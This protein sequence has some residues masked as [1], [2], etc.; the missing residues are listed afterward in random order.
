MQSKLTLNTV[1]H[2]KYQCHKLS[3][4]KF[5]A[6]R[7]SK[8]PWKAIHIKPILKHHLKNKYSQTDNHLIMIMKMYREE[9]L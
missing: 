6:C 1:K 3:F 8:E 5:G 7:W 4:I 9:E 2:N